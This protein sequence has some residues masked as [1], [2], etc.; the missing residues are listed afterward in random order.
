MSWPGELIP[1]VEC[2]ASNQRF[3]DSAGY[4]PSCPVLSLVRLTHPAVCYNVPS[5][6]IAIATACLL[7][8]TSLSQACSLSPSQ[9]QS[10]LLPWLCKAGSVAAFLF[11]GK[12]CPSLFFCHER[13]ASRAAH[14]LSLSD[15]HPSLALCQQLL[16]PPKKHRQSFAARG[17]RPLVVALT[18]GASTTAR[19]RRDGHAPCIQS[20]R[21]SSSCLIFFYDTR[22]SGH[23]WIQMCQ[24]VP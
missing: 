4:P 13:N 15:F 11:R 14:A 2:D 7:L 10:L 19:S 20:R 17:R 22:P 24:C 18:T 12:L 16:Q 3:L 9:Q 8:F 5:H 6:I 23:T 1:A 21:G